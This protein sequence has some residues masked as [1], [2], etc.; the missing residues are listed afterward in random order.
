MELFRRDRQ[1]LAQ[2]T[3]TH[4]K[5]AFDSLREGSKMRALVA[6]LSLV[7]VALLVPSL[8]IADEPLPLAPAAA[9]DGYVAPPCGDADV[10][11]LAAADC[12][13]VEAVPSLDPDEVANP[14]SVQELTAKADAV[15]ALEP[16]PE[17][18]PAYCRLHADVYFYTSADWMRL[19][20]AL[21][22]NESPC[23]DYYISIPG[24][25]ADK[26]QLRC[27]QDDVIR[28]LGARFHPVA[29]FHFQ[30]WRD[31]W[32]KNGKTPA[33]AAHEFLRRVRAC[34]YDFAR[35]ETWSLNELHSG[36]YQNLPGARANMRL[37]L[38]TLHAGLPEMPESRGIV[39][40]VG[41]GHGSQNLGPY[42]G[43]VEKW[44]QDALFWQDM[45][46]DVA[47]WGQEAYA[48]MP[49]WGVADASRNERT[50]NV[51]LFLEHPL[52]LAEAGPASVA[53]ALEFL[54]QTYVPLANA[55]WPYRS[56]FGNTFFP[57]DA[58]Q[59]FVSEQTF[60]VK[61]FA[62]SRPQAAPAERIA[63]AWAPNTQCGTDLCNPASVFRQRTAGI[64]ER[65][66]SAI[67]E[68]YEQG[69]GSQEGACGPPGDH[70]WCTADI[71]EAVFN[72]L[73]STFPEW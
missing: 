11:T 8:A 14:S 59:R 39:W 56:G 23:A 13:G 3:F 68:S 47:V 15:A 44:L 42:K 73:W 43:F 32:I 5:G 49:F 62:Q 17:D 38:N 22:A 18:L 61:H 40:A 41:V 50:R 6:V 27:A 57:D 4:S 45:T 29:E 31:W 71:P 16:S 10:D 7:L 70:T 48:S 33:D 65:L 25:A 66:A 60:A 37:L 12:A 26:T 36:V 1:L 69:G 9:D 19:G 53:T 24:L 34:G 30:D 67:R 55:A 52:L 20:E 72:P 28:A 64:L 46:S 35:G 51:S 58:M 54:E 63:F 21:Q 2:M